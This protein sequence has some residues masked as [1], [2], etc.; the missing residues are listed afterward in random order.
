MDLGILGSATVPT[1]DT[2]QVNSYILHL[3]RMLRLPTKPQ[4]LCKRWP[5]RAEQSTQGLCVRE[6]WLQCP[7]LPKNL[8]VQWFSVAF[9]DFQCCWMW[10]HIGDTSLGVSVRVVPEKIN[11]DPS[12]RL[13]S[14]TE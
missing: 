13:G 3:P 4:V 1:N 6:L 8:M 5:D 2:K 14:Q 10:N 7:F 9:T 12:H 11:Q